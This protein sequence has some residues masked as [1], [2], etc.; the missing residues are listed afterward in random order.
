MSMRY[1]T[2]VLGLCLAIAAVGLPPSIT[3]TQEL[4]VPKS[5]P[6]IFAIFNSQVLNYYKILSANFTTNIM[7]EDKISLYG[8]EFI[9]VQ[10]QLL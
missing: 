7:P 3:A 6:I 8:R 5:M 1:V 10:F 2:S 4:V 9:L